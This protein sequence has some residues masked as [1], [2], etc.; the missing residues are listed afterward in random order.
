MMRSPIDRF[1]PAVEL[2]TAI[3]RMEV[4][5]V[6]VAESYLDRIDELDPRLN[7]F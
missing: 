5:P 4:S 2:A 3:R 7:A 6:E 1:T